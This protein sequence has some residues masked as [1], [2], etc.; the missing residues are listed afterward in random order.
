ML[1]THQ[2]LM[3]RLRSTPAR[4]MLGL[5]TLAGGAI[6][7]ACESENFDPPSYTINAETEDRLE[8]IESTFEKLPPTKITLRLPESFK[9]VEQDVVWRVNSA[10]IEPGSNIVESR[11]GRLKIL[12]ENPFTELSSNILLRGVL[13]HDATGVELTIGRIEHTKASE[14]IPDQLLPPENENNEV[15]IISIKVPQR[16]GD[17]IRTVGWGGLTFYLQE[18]EALSFE[19][20]PDSFRT[21]RIYP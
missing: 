9:E 18:V 21:F 16:L 4:V 17:N 13:V 6:F 1:E 10:R 19:P 3:R 14:V 11:Q 5:T 2:G 12:T 15:I 8:T 7:V 20:N